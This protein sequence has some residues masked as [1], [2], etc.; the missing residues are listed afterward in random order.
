[1]K[2][3]YNR[4]IKAKGK[5]YYKKSNTAL[6]T[7]NKGVLPLSDRFVTKLR[8]CDKIS[9]P[10]TANILGDYS[11]RLN[12]LFDPDLTG[13]G[14]QPYGF[15]QLALFYNRYRVY[16]VDYT[17]VQQPN[18]ANTGTLTTVASNSSGSFAGFVLSHIQEMSRCN[19]KIV[20]IDEPTVLKGSVYL[21]KLNGDMP[22]RYKTDDRFQA[23]VN[24]NPVEELTLHVCPTM[25]NSV[26]VTFDI[27][28]DFYCEFFDP[29]YLNQS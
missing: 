22:I 19:T 6:T 27:R 14:H 8:Y 9:V 7:V 17:I 20:R 2:K 23:S 12:S 3:P 4:K 10:V 21:P 11:F 26:T 25:T 16:K 15:D 29:K 1:M 13:T 5:K 28:M 24:T 18:N